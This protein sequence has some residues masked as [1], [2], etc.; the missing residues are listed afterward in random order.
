[1][2]LLGPRSDASSRCCWTTTGPGHGWRLWF[3]R[4]KVQL[5]QVRATA[6][7]TLPRLVERGWGGVGGPGM[8]DLHPMTWP[9]LWFLVGD[10][11]NSQN[12]WLTCHSEKSPRTDFQTLEHFWLTPKTC[13]PARR[14]CDDIFFKLVRSKRGS[15]RSSRGLAV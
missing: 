2:R 6:A 12:Y 1:M 9:A 13:V 4:I 11:C 8:S 7:R 5:R 15:C 3:T 10:P 14:F